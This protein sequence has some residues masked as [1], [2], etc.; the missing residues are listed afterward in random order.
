MAEAMLRARLETVA[1]EIVVGSAGLLFDG[2]P[3]E[4]NAIKVMR[5]QG[6]DLSEHAAQKISVD[7]LGGASLILGMQR[8]HVREVATLDPALFNRSF[9][10]PEFVNAARIVGAR[11]PGEDLRSWVEHIGSLRNPADYSFADRASEIADPM[12]GSVR[13]FRTCAE[14]IDTRL[15]ALVALAWPA[16]TPGD[17]AVAPATS[18]GIHADRDRR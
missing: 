16:P 2:R 5:K 1:P 18:G 17:P 12:G 7:L 10:L 11:Q 13:A 9:T 6:L 8:S 3:A 14:A 15:E 4:A